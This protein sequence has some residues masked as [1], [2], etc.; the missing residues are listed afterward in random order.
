[1]RL[2]W[3]LLFALTQGGS[4]GPPMFRVMLSMTGELAMA[5]SFC[6][7]ADDV[8]SL[9]LMFS[10]AAQLRAFA[11]ISCSCIAGCTQAVGKGAGNDFAVL[12]DFLLEALAGLSRLS[13]LCQQSVSWNRRGRRSV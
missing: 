9:G 1:M 12:Q 7:L 8:P 10:V 6:G 13:G 4:A 5:G 3:F 2:N 11:Q